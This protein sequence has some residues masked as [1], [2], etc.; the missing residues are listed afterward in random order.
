MIF[1]L[2]RYLFKILIV[3]FK[4]APKK[5]T[6]IYVERKDRIK[7][8]PKKGNHLTT[9]EEEIEELIDK[10]SSEMAEALSYREV[11]DYR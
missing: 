9:K 6:E 8:T 4:L 7:M 2:D 1:Q 3:I 11:S 5:R 10:L